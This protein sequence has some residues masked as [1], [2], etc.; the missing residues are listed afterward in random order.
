MCFCLTEQINQNKLP[1]RPIDPRV[2]SRGPD[3]TPAF[4]DF[5]RQLQG[6][7]GAPVCPITRSIT[8]SHTHTENNMELCLNNYNK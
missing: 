4:A 2:I 8:Y 7:R 6:G 5:G 1:M 3:F